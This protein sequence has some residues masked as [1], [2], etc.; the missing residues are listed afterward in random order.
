MNQKY[1]DRFIERKLLGK[2]INLTSHGQHLPGLKQGVV[3]ISLGH[4]V[5][6][7][8]FYGFW[9]C[10]VITYEVGAGIMPI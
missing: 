5:M 9:R 7:R 2:F 6:A 8:G 4:R 3:F 1:E 10:G